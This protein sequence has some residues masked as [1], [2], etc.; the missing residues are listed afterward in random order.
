M[1]V[2]GDMPWG[3]HVCMFYESKEDLLD[4]VGP[5]FNAGLESNE[6]CLWAPSDP[7][8]V[9]EARVALSRRIPDFD[10]HL[11]AG[12][13]EIVAAREWYLD[14]DRFD[15]E[16]INRAWDEKLRGALAKDYEGMRACGNA[17]WLHT[18]HWEDFCDYERQLDGIL[19]GKPMVILC[20]YP[21]A[22]SSAAAVLEVAQAHQLA[23]ARQRGEWV[24][25][26][27]VPAAAHVLTLREREV[28]WWAAQ[29]KSAW[30]IG[31]ILHIAKRT[32]DQHTQNAARKLGAVNR[33]QAVALA[34]RE[35][36]IG[37]DPPSGKLEASAKPNWF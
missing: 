34:L 3:S 22:V 15:L 12:N 25:V 14:G 30:E 5:Y 8:T 4:T 32:V 6:F 33:T 29:G 35:R 17:F 1:N 18:K 28:L 21:I 31:E 36:L 37:N 27:T 19:A 7:V 20:A 10:R 2:L 24:V 9:D 16:R 11:A 26:E 23:V 13:M